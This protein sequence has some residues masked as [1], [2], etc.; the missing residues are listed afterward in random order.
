MK[1]PLDSNRRR[2]QTCGGMATE[3][4]LRVWT[5][6]GLIDEAA[7]ARIRDF[8]AANERPVALWA[9]VGLGLLALA[10]GIILVVSANWDRIPDAVKLSVHFALTAAAAAA[11]WWGAARSKPWLAEGSL[12]LLGALVLAGIG[13]HAQVYQLT[14]PLW[15]ALLLWLA[16]MTPALLLGGSTRLTGIGWALMTLGAMLSVALDHAEARGPWL[17]VHGAAMATPALLVAL[18]CVPRLA[19]AFAAGVREIAIIALLAAASIAHF[20]WA[21]EVPGSEAADMA[22]RFILPALAAALALLSNRRTGTMP[23]GLLLALVAGPTLAAALALAVPHPDIWVSRLLGVLTF[24]ALWGWIARE[25]SA[26]G[27]S[28]LFAVAVAAIAIRIFV[29]YIE[30]FGSLAATGGGLIAG[31]ALLVL[32]AVAWRRIVSRRKP[33]A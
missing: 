25:A 19:S 6:A 1:G 2:R 18:S 31:G 20:G 3:S 27:R 16:L 7:A 9:M 14:G 29:I 4:K 13:L 23:Q 28:A 26:D 17:W 32:L 5:E 10:L 33:V 21:S 24:A 15:H 11:A 22:L 30:L 12:F 8:E